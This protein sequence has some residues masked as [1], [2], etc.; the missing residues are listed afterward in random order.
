MPA[1]QYS[2][3]LHRRGGITMTVEVPEPVPDA[4]V[5]PSEVPGKD[6]PDRPTGQ[7]AE[8]LFRRQSSKTT[9]GALHYVQDKDLPEPGD[10]PTTSSPSR[11]SSCGRASAM[12]FV[13]RFG[14]DESLGEG[15]P[16]L[17]VECYPGG[18]K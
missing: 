15:T 16:R 3:T 8:R 11:C 17:C 18:A 4:I 2:A 12:F 1:K 6:A 5:R 10:G 9:D 13:S 7:F 14:A